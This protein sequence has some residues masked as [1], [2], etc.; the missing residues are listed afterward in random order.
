MQLGQH[1]YSFP[2]TFDR[3]DHQVTIRPSAVETDSGLVLLD[4]GFP[5]QLDEL[6]SAMGEH[7][8]DLADVET[9]VLTHQDGDHA[10]GASDLVS[11]TG[12]TVVAHRSDTPAIEGDEAPIK[13][14]GDRYPPVPVDVQV[15]EG[16]VFRT[17]AG[18]MWVV[19]TPG[20]TPGHVSLVLP[21][22]GLLIAGDALTA[23]ED[24]LAGPNERFTPEM[25][26]AVDSV[27]KL[28]QFDVGQTLC[29][30][31]GAVDGDD[32]DVRAVYESLTG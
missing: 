25:D 21:D 7:G 28:T 15:V 14:S 24:G 23:N 22:A 3:G 18:P 1:V 12:A 16:V 9:L 30:H 20:H 26:E 11:R 6:A 17:E 8:L 13:S 2:L 31:G 19:E 27:G 10:G 4:A 32:A 5:G 29:Y